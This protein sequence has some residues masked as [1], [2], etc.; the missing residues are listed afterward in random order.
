MGRKTIAL[1]L[2]LTAV[3][4]VPAASLAWGADTPDR[5]DAEPLFAD[6]TRST[7]APAVP[8]A[9]L[10]VGAP[11]RA[12]LASPSIRSEA[13]AGAR[14]GQMERPPVAARGAEAL[15]DA[16]ATL[17]RTPGA[18]SHDATSAPAA[19]SR[20]SSPTAWAEPEPKPADRAAAPSNE[21]AAEQKPEAAPAPAARTLTVGGAVIP[22]RDVRG[23]TTPSSGAGLWLGSDDVDDGSWGYFVGH[24]PGSFAPVRHLAVGD[25]VV[26]C[27]GNGDHRAYTVRTVFT[28]EAA[29]TWK[30]IASHV[31]GYGESVILQTCTGDGATNTIA[32]AA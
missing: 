4:A 10:A 11:V 24:N 5:P 21:R 3:I 7:V 29:A 25:S 28:V 32:V 22:Y 17:G 8:G 23:G 20:R 26:L 16:L 31:T 2:V 12:R 30:A 15:G 18:T 1:A 13:A 9:P 14:A 27:N 6:G 19:P